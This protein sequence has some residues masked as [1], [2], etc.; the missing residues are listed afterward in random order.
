MSIISHI[1]DCLDAL[2][3]P[4]AR[5]DALTRDIVDLTGR[6]PA[7]EAELARLTAAHPPSVLAAVRDN[8]GMARE[9][10]TFAEQNIDNGR[11]A[12]A[13]P[14][15]QQGGAVAAI[16]AAE[17]AIGQARALLDAIAHAGANIQQARDGLPA[18]LDEFLAR[19]RAELGEDGTD[20]EDSP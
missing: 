10:I 17:G 6:V 4:S 1:R 14:V 9:D 18:V 13:Q 5:Y 8:I 7:A 16:R 12:L 15:G 11:N 19:L 20:S 2:L 3:H